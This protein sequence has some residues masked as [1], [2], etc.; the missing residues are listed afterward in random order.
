MYQS[1]KKIVQKCIPKAILMKNEVAFRKLYATF[2]TGNSKECNIC[3]K[4][5]S[6]FIINN[7]NESMCP[8]C[9]S[10]ERD[11]RL[12]SLLTP[13]FIKENSKILDFSPSRSLAR[14]LKSIRN[15]SYFPSDLSGHFLADYQ[16]DIT[17]IE[18]QDATFDLICCYHILEHIEEDRLA[19]NELFRVLKSDGIIFIQTPFKDGDT[20]ENESITSEKDRLEHFGQEDHV[21]IYSE[22][23]LKERLQQAGFTIEI[24]HF[25]EEDNNYFGFSKK[26][27]VF[28]ATKS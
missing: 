9:G 27:T 20:Y 18:A 4:K 12:W 10:L 3:N 17:K 8:K 15:I 5:L 1:L 7:K 2:Y 14:K 19:M 22:N 24:K 11:R 16:F 21:R 23:G 13:N 6:R 28:L 25:S 26:E